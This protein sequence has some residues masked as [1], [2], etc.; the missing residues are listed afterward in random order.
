MAQFR[1]ILF[2][3]SVFA[4]AA[5]PL[6][7]TWFYQPWPDLPGTHFFTTLVFALLF[8]AL[9]R[10][11]EG[12][13][14]RLYLGA[15]SAVAVIVIWR[16]IEILANL[17]V[18]DDIQAVLIGPTSAAP[19]MGVLT[20]LALLSLLLSLLFAR[21]KLGIP[22][23]AAFVVSA[24][25]TVVS[26]IGHAVGSQNY[27]GEMA[28]ITTGLM[29]L[30]C[31]AS[32]EKL[33]SFEPIQFFFAGQTYSRNM[34]LRAVLYNVNILI[35]ALLFT[36]L[37]SRFENFLPLIVMA[38]IAFQ[39][40]LFVQGTYTYVRSVKR[41]NK[42]K[43]DLKSLS[44]KA[45]RASE[46]KSKFLAVISHELRTPLT[47]IIGLADLLRLTKL[48]QE[49]NKHLKELTDS[50]ENLTLL[51][52]EVLDFSKI[53]S[54]HLKLE[55]RA[56]SL[57]ELLRGIQSLFTSVAS[58][59]GYLL[60]LEFSDL[61]QDAVVGDPTRLRQVIT[62]IVNNA[63]K[64]TEKGGVTIEVTQ[65][66]DESGLARTS[67]AVK[68]T[69]QGI[70]ADRLDSIFDAFSQVDDTIT[71]QFGGTGLGLSIATSLMDFMGGDIQVESVVGLGSKFTVEVPLIV[72]NAAQIEEIRQRQNYRASKN[73]LI[74]QHLNS[75]QNART[76]NAL[77]TDDNETIRQLVTTML[78][79]AGHTVVSATNG[80]EAIDAYKAQTFDVIFM[81]MHMP[82]MNG[83]QASSAIRE[84]EA[85]QA[86][87]KRTPIIALTADVLEENTQRCLEAGIDRVIGKPINWVL[88]FETIDEL[89]DT[90]SEHQS[91][92]TA[93]DANR[94][95][96][97]LAQKTI[98]EESGEHDAVVVQGTPDTKSAQSN[99]GFMGLN[100][101]N[102]EMV[103]DLEDALGHEVTSPMVLNF[104]ES[105]AG[106]V[107][108]FET[109][110][111][112]ESIE[113]LKKKGHAINGLCQQF[114]AQRLGE[115]AAF[116]EYDAAS[117]EEMK[118]LLPIL[119]ADSQQ[120]TTL[121]NATE[122][123]APQG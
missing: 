30:A 123:R 121:V 69:G 13:H 44:E 68:D 120:I 34:G 52:N 48:N 88:L 101:L 109:A 61:K 117:V 79:K 92:S 47:G 74:A 104:A 39:F 95:S 17:S 96:G 99:Q 15:L 35:L 55:H 85:A 118:A 94:A 59:K 4:L 21:A 10:K 2:I 67:I 8:F 51:L 45:N 89:V 49:Q 112:T 31:A 106:H 53:E 25:I 64:F 80:K 14:Q 119:K 26:L 11:D 32:F 87:K 77:V 57:T 54:G 110:V 58:A 113:D 27:Y 81:D 1:L 24:G 73:D 97:S 116:I 28:V 12:Q 43:D 108:V 33:K 23:Q 65:S 38:I 37:D 22:A 16:F 107:K 42:Q 100:V 63:I 76:L 40:T 83:I 103:R 18:L 41:E 102:F 84:Y 70:P 115:V 66:V 50:A 78:T 122:G 93:D 36:R 9:T 7:W 90:S 60:E 6:Q 62:N 46:A 56:F 5:Y 86:K 19:S 114:G 3:F 20:D 105:L 75:A 91:P 72:A 29:L 111:E 71:R 98:D 82:V